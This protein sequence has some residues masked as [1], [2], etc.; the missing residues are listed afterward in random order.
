V[1]LPPMS[2]A[3]EQDKVEDRWPAAE[4]FIVEHRLNEVFGRGTPAWASSCRAAT[5]TA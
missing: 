3:H 1:V 4:R 2:F 5:T